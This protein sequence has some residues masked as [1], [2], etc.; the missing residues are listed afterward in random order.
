MDEIHNPA[1]LQIST[2]NENN[3][4]QRA[5]VDWISYDDQ[6]FWLH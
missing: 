1:R 4:M 2:E 6:E 5:N 3:I